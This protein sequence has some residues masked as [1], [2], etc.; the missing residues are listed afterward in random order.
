MVNDVFA[1]EVNVFHERSAIFAVENDVLLFTRR[2]AALYNYPHRVRRALRR[3][4][5][6]RR[7]EK[8][9]AL[10]DSVIDDPVAFADPHLD[11][12][13]ELVEVLF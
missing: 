4:R 10:A 2:T 1:V 3:V 6:I 7:N 11:V 9:L 8:R 12:S 13:F 5:H